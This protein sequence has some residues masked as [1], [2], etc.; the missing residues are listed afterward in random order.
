MES[1]G[2]A[3]KTWAANGVTRHSANGRLWTK[4]AERWSCRRDPP[5]WM[6]PV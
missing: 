4:L 2:S 1:H 5:A 6:Q 3:R